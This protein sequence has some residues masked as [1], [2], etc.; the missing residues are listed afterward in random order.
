MK[1]LPLTVEQALGVAHQMATETGG[2][3]L[4]VLDSLDIAI[5]IT[6]ERTLKTVSLQVSTLRE[7]CDSLGISLADV[8]IRA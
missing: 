5:G 4:F 7:I 2:G 1:L 3:R 8:S 6:H